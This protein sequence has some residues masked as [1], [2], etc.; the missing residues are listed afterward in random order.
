MERDHSGWLH[1]ASQRP[2]LEGQRTGLVRGPALGLCG[3]DSVLWAVDG[4]FISAR[5]LNFDVFRKVKKRLSA[6]INKQEG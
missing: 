6:K 5:S 1:T 3:L 2:I 4:P